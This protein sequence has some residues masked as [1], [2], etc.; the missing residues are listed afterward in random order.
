MKN[1]FYIDEPLSD[2]FANSKILN[3]ESAEGQRMKRD[4]FV[5]LASYGFY[6]KSKHKFEAPLSQRSDIFIMNQLD[7]DQLAILYSIAICDTGDIGIIMNNVDVA[8]ICME[9]ANAGLYYLKKLENESPLNKELYS[10]RIIIKEAFNEFYG[11]DV[12]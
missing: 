10:F 3:S 2:F 8:N 5:L 12:G 6:L 9:Y 1:H 11:E 7:D 4:E